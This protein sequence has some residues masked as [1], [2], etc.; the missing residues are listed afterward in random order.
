MGTKAAVTPTYTARH[1]RLAKLASLNAP[2]NLLVNEARM[3]V[4][5][6]E[7]CDL[8][9]G[10][11]LRYRTIAIW[12]LV[13]LCKQNSDEIMALKRQIRDLKKRAKASA[14]EAVA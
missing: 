3:L 7:E 14:K 4:R 11:T 6:D 8:K 1:E 13:C 2:I 5:A 12:A 10:M 9:Y